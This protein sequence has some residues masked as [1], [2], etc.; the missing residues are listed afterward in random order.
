[1][2]SADA[3]AHTALVDPAAAQ[4]PYHQSQSAGLLIG[5]APPRPVSG[6]GD[7]PAAP[8]DTSQ[9]GLEEQLLSELYTLKDLKEANEQLRAEMDKRVAP[10]Q[11][12]LNTVN[13]DAGLYEGMLKNT[14][15]SGSP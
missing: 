8:E 7:P 12:A 9:L 5:L 6:Q 11:P 2:R 13:M 14:K 1:M 3:L 10:K 15:T 4:A